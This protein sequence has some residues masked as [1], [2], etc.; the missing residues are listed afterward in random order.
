[1]ETTKKIYE[2][3]DLTLPTTLSIVASEYCA[4]NK[5]DVISG[6]AHIV[7]L[8]QTDVFGVFTGSKPSVNK[9]IK[10]L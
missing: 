5:A 3:T 2:I 1:M 9:T 4:V 6:I 7:D 10:A 8:V